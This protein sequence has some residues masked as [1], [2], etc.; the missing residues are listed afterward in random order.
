MT[1]QDAMQFHL[2]R[3]H[4]MRGFADEQVEENGR[5][6]W[7]RVM[8]LVETGEDPHDNVLARGI[9][10]YGV[11]RGPAAL[12]VAFMVSGARRRRRGNPGARRRSAKRPTDAQLRLD[13]RQLLRDLKAMSADQFRDHRAAIQSHRLAP[14]AV[15]IETLAHRHHLSFSDVRKSVHT[16][17]E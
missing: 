5:D 13:Y 7:R 16:N 4:F 10:R 17:H 1:D 12:Y 3:D 11:P 6:F 14:W 15:A 9:A 2:W 8:E